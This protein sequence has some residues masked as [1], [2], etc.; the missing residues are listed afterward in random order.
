MA[1]KFDPPRPLVLDEHREEAFRVFKKQWERYSIVSK[2]ADENDAYRAALLMYTVGEPA[3]KIVESSGT[4]HKTVDQ[5][6]EILKTHCIGTKNELYHDFVFGTADQKDGE[7]FDTFLARLRSLETICDFGDLK[8]RMIRN[9]VVLG[10]QSNET[11][12]KLLASSEQTLEAITKLCK[13]EERATT[14][15]RKIQADETVSVN[16]VYNNR[17]FRRTSER[18]HD[19]SKTVDCKYC[20]RIHPHK[21]EACK[22]FGKICN[23][24]KG[25]NHFE[26]VCMKKKAAEGRQ[27]STH[28][29]TSGDSD[30]ESIDQITSSTSA[31]KIMTRLIVVKS[32]LE[33]KFQVDSGSTVNILRHDMLP[34]GTPIVQ[35]GT[36]LTSWTNDSQTSMG[37]AKVMVRNPTNNKKYKVLFHVV[38]EN[39]TPILGLRASIA[40]GM[41][42][43]NQEN[44]NTIASDGS[45]DI[46]KEFPSVFDGELGDLPGI[47]KLQIS[48]NAKPH[49]SPV[50]RVPHAIHSEVKTELEKMVEK[51]I[52]TPVDTPT[53]WESNMV[54]AKKS[55][56]TLRICIDPQRLNEAL[57]RESYL[58]PT[59]D[60][61]LPQFKYARLFSVVDLKSGYWHV[62]LD[63]ESAALTCMN[64]PFGRYRWLR[65][66]FGLK[67]SSEI[68]QKQLHRALWDVEGVVCV[69]DD[70]VVIGC[71]L[72]NED[73]MASHDSRMRALLKRCEE[74]NIKLNPEK[75]QLRQKSIK[76]LGHIVTDQ[77]LLPD[78]MKIHSVAEMKEPQNEKELRSFLG[79]VQYLSKFLYNLAPIAV[80]LREATKGETWNWTEAQSKAFAKAKALITAEPVMLQY[81]D[82]TKELTV[83]CDASDKSIGAALLQNDQPLE[84]SSRSL[85]D[86]ETRYAPIE[87]ELL[88]V[89]WAVE[90]Y[91]QYTYGRHTTVLSDHKPLE[92]IMLKPLRDVPKRLQNLRMRLQQYD[93]TVTYLPGS[94][95]HIADM[96]SRHGKNTD[97]SADNM[98]PREAINCLTESVDALTDTIAG[99]WREKLNIESAKCQTLQAVKEII[100]LGWPE[101][102]EKVNILA[103]PYHLMRDEMAVHDGLVYRGERVIVPSS[104]R[105]EL[106]QELHSSHQGIKAT[107]R[108]AREC[109]YWPGMSTEIEDFIARCETCQRHTTKQQQET[110][111]KTKLADRPWQ[112][113][114]TDLFT[115]NETEYMVTVDH[116]SNFIEID[117]IE[118]K[119]AQT[120]VKKLKKH[121]ARYGLAETLISDNGPQFTS[122]T[123]EKFTK[124]YNMRHQTSSPHHPQ[125]NGKA[126]SAVK[127]AKM[128]ITK[129]NDDGADAYLALLAHRNTPQEGFE[130]SPAQRMFGRRCRTTL[131]TT[132]SLLQPNMNDTKRTRSML[133][134]KQA[135]DKVQFDSHAKDLEPLESG[136]TVVLKP[137]ALGQKVWT[138]AQVTQRLDE[139]SYVVQPEKGSL[140]RRNR[141]DLKK[142][143]SPTQVNTPGASDL[144]RPTPP[145]VEEDITERT[146]QP[147][148]ESVEAPPV[149]PV[150]TTRYGRVI[151]LPVRYRE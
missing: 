86:A 90:R 116:F 47:Q 41:I 78:P 129:A 100:M 68:F 27:A 106:K 93:V 144:K 48:S 131:P 35:D 117:R 10:I 53:P 136:D 138:R 4:E 141:V 148:A 150:K 54:V 22:A 149:T 7:D 46:V 108:R 109:L 123:F 17:G 29:I 76:F 145:R 31:K 45:L 77:G 26:T 96:L 44:I 137:V 126:E 21:K 72:T 55:N 134:R 88:A 103:R 23:Y 14:T 110:M 124:K 83:H 80:C 20:G 57:Q 98:L 146:N 1:R 74:L 139:R 33:I 133:A 85:K 95:Q 97:D 30:H 94:R 102:K 113:V 70:I 111:M 39:R 115:C 38:S 128:L 28:L 67:V 36:V 32:A 63:D 87:K 130:E 99:P 107:L 121:M 104:L 89:V 75:I 6:L 12:R 69:A 34:Q 42:T 43:I 62:K 101:E 16:A 140:I 105:A 49:A 84:F 56:G 11:R 13:S 125:G 143:P 151:T 2:L 40:M 64:T 51:G 66:P 50:R 132:A 24:C 112:I 79:F 120:I 25:S 119:D 3:V 127:T 9:R 61:V 59:L 135:T 52:I 15:L 60:D 5:I 142:V 147:L 71:G 37:T 73:A 122:E 92:R 81:Y 19:N 65:M 82:P 8:D 58:M 18:K 114:S 118:S 91:H